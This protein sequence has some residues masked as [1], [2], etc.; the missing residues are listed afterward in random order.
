MRMLRRLALVATLAALGCGGGDDDDN[1]NPTGP[2][3]GGAT[4]GTFTV[5]VNGTTWSATGT[6]TV[7]R[8][9]NNFIGLAGS[10]FAGNTAYSFVVGIG[11]ATGPGTHNLNVFAGGDGSSVIVGSTTTGYGTAFQGGGGTLTITTLTTN[12]IA[13]TFSGTAVP[14]SGGGANLV[15]TSGQFDITF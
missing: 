10:G 1:G 11:N 4:N 3:A 15:L 8:Q 6:V 9:S 12:R 7:S 13:G 14:S 2:G 5:V